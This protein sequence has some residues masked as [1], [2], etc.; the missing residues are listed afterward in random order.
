MSSSFIREVGIVVTHLAFWSQIGVL[1][2]IYLDKFFL[3]GCNGGWGLC[4]TSEGTPR[5]IITDIVAQRAK[6]TIEQLAVRILSLQV[7]DVIPWVPTSLT[8]LPTCLAPTSWACWQP[9]TLWDCPRERPWQ[10]YQL[11]ASSRCLYL[12]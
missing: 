12:P 2:R 6:R 9:P 10:S 3:D 4:L 11:A 7:C 5:A 8:W 1:T